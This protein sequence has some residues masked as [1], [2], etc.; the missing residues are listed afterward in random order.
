MTNPNE[1]G[2]EW[3]LILQVDLPGAAKQFLEKLAQKIKI[4]IKRIGAV[5]V[6]DV[7]CGR[8]ELIHSLAKKLP[9]CRFVGYD[10][11]RKMIR[12]LNKGSLHN[13]EFAYL[14]LPKVPDRLFDCVL[15]INTLHYI[16]EPLLSIKNLWSIVRP[17][18]ILIFNYPNR[19]YKALLP[20]EPQDKNWAIVEKPMRKGI[21]ILSQKRIREAVLN[22]RMSYL[23]KSGRHNI[24]LLLEKIG[25]P[26]YR[27]R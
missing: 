11:S 22:A 10:I 26:N 5:D 25:R 20:K 16:Q 12:N 21:N 17:K 4:E 19:Y 14:S 23:H 8:G 6:A 13:E 27:K 18:G 24:Y 1:K 2:T 9:K 7:G 15:C 3:D